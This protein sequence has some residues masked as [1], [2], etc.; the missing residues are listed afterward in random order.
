MKLYPFLGETNI[1]QNKNLHMDAYSTVIHSSH[2]ENNPYSW[3]NKI[4]LHTK[5]YSNIRRNE[6]LIIRCDKD[7]PTLHDCAN[8]TS[9][10]GF[11]EAQK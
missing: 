8:D 2:S 5:K 10:Q 3:V 7:E 4:Y 11:T 1:W 9:E 6:I